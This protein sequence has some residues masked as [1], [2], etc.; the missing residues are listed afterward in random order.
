MITEFRTGGIT[1]IL[2]KS[3]FQCLSPSEFF[4]LQ[5]YFEI[6]IAPILVMEILGDLKKE[7]NDSINSS[8]VIAF[9]KKLSSLIPSVN[10]HFS[11]LIEEELLGNIS[12]PFYSCIVD[13]GE[14]LKAPNGEKVIKI[15]PSLE[16]DAL[17]RW[18]EGNFTEVDRLISKFWR[19]QTTRPNI[20]IDLQKY[21][22]S[23][24]PEFKILKTQQ[25]ILYLI[26]STFENQELLSS[27]LDMVIKEFGISQ[28]SASKI[29]YRWEISVDKNLRK[30]APYSFFCLT[31]KILFNICLQNN[32][33]GTKPTNLLD[34]EYIYY[35]PFC[36][37]FISDDIFHKKLVPYLLTSEQLFFSGK[38]IK[39]D[40]TKIEQIKLTLSDIDLKRAHSQ[41]PR[42]EELLIYKIWNRMFLDWPPEKDW[43]PSHE[44]IEMIE[45]AVTNFRN[46]K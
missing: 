9:S 28:S 11:V 3:A 8:K 21:L 6:N 32:I 39:E 41:P 35:L 27:L 10:S 19:E 24:T 17:N 46:A 26:N 13:T 5:Q 12:M 29:F 40:L 45:R 44:E 4:Q 43:V 15:H 25:D 36:K 18:K 20:L 34:L 14:L 42:K 38:E 30:F 22:S 37:V 33:I 23:E 16:A 1:I 31:V 2:D 7:N